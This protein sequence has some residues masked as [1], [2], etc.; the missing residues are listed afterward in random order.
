[1]LVFHRIRFKRVVL[2]ITLLHGSG[3]VTE[4]FSRQSWQTKWWRCWQRYQRGLSIDKRHSH[5][6]HNCS[7]K[8]WQKSCFGLLA[9]DAIFLMNLCLQFSAKLS[10]VVCCW[11]AA[12][13]CAYLS[14]LVIL[15]SLNLSSDYNSANCKYVSQPH[16]YMII[17][18]IVW[19]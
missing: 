12:E 18:K 7:L 3:H 14:Q 4:G 15:S 11:F 16:R 2:L 13:N 6:L 1:M 19:V 10:F 8:I 17:E 9:A 5:I